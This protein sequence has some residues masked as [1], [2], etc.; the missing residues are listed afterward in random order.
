MNL[1]TDQQLNEAKA[2]QQWISKIYKYIDK[3]H[4]KKEQKYLQISVKDVLKKITKE[5]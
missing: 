4:I 5:I 2:Q 1:F 3:K